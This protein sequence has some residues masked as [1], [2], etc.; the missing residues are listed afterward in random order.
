MLGVLFGVKALFP[1]LGGNAILDVLDTDV[2]ILL[3]IGVPAPEAGFG[4]S[5]FL[6][7]SSIIVARKLSSCACNT[8]DSDQYIMNIMFTKGMKETSQNY[9]TQFYVNKEGSLANDKS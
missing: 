7:L 9:H 2:G 4:L 3:A 8:W 1:C 5:L 6:I